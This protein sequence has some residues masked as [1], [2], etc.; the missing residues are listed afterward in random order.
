[1]NLKATNCAEAE[2]YIKREY[3]AGWTL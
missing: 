2:K 3:R 1:V